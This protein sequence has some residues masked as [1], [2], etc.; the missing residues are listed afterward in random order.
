LGEDIER[1]LRDGLLSAAPVSGAVEAIKG[2]NAGPY[3][4]IPDVEMTH[5][6]RL[7]ERGL[8]LIGALRP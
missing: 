3:G 4:E 5:S 1:W 6:Y 2:G 8:A 7:T